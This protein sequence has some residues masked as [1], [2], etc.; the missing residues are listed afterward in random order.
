VQTEVSP[1]ES[2]WSETARATGSR[3]LPLAKRLRVHARNL[4]RIRAEDRIA[5]HAAHGATAVRI[6][7]VGILVSLIAVPATAVW[8]DRT[9]AVAPA[10]LPLGLL[11]VGCEAI[12]F[13]LERRATRVALLVA[14]KLA[15]FASLIG[16]AL[17][18]FLAADD[19][20]SYTRHPL[21]F[22]V[23]VLF[24]GAAGLRNDPRLPLCAGV[25]SAL[26]LLVVSLCIPGIAAASPPVKA[27]A[28]HRD[29]D[30]EYQLGRAAILLCATAIAV[31]SAARGR[32]IRRLS[33]LDGLTGLVNRRAF[34]AFLADE[35]ARARR[36]GRP[37]ALAMIDVDHFKQLNDAHGHAAGDG[38][39]RWL[40]EQLRTR[41]R[42]T[43]VV[44]RYGGEEFAL[45]F[46]DAE[47]SQVRARLESLRLSVAASHPRL[48]RDG[49]P[50]QVTLSIGLASCPA[51]GDV[52]DAALSRADA[53][54]YQAKRC[55]RNRLVDAA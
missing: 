38:V 51:D 33:V 46:V 11:A 27:A 23:F 29:F 1:A 43:D 44:A 24:I 2:P 6:L 36:A 40:A 4:L 10:L 26:S 39:L 30:L 16:A 9:H 25:C 18:S 50:V 13:V 41:L 34:D 12:W 53:R 7:T 3:H 22:L 35:G 17:W 52:A 20:I 54:L 48:G 19:P 37:L 49:D 55:G 21:M 47:A 8:F 28:L 14:V 15:I 45:V 5:T 42:T 32:A 31:T